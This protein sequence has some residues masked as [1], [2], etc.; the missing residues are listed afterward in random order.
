[1]QICT[2]RYWEIYA[3]GVSYQTIVAA[4]RSD[5]V[6]QED[7]SVRNVT[8]WIYEIF[9]YFYIFIV[10]VIMSDRVKWTAASVSRKAAFEESPGSAGQG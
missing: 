10:A 3:C 9:I 8:V 1:M 5:T 2:Y 6:K 7:I 4:A